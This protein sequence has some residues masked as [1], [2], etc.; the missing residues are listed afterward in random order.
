MST[1]TNEA[2]IFLPAMSRTDLELVP[3]FLLFDEFSS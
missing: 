3:S 2:R 1:L